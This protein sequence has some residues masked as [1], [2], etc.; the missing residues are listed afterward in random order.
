MSKRESVSCR[1][2]LQHAS[3]GTLLL[4]LLLYSCS[5]CLSTTYPHTHTHNTL[6][7]APL[8]HWPS[9]CR[10]LIFAK[11]KCH[12]VSLALCISCS[13]P[14]LD[15]DSCASLDEYTFGLALPIIV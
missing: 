5:D 11:W 6:L 1:L 10:Q 7:C 9:R 12:L 2:C 13:L 3:H 15:C 8:S 14:C 4:L